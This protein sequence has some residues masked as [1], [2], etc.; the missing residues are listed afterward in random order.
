MSNLWVMTEEWPGQWQR[1]AD[2]RYL[3]RR[4]SEV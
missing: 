1:W 2:L 4:R 3:W